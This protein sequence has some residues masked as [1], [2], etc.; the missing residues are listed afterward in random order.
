MKKILLPILVFAIVLTMSDCNSNEI[1]K[2]PEF[3]P[4]EVTNLKYEIVKGP[5]KEPVLV[6]ITWDNPSDP[7]FDHVNIGGD[8][9]TS[10]AVYYQ[11]LEMEPVAGRSIRCVNKHGKSSKGIRCTFGY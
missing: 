8:N 4:F 10:G 9:L 5:P 1:E 3:Y 6:K 11:I 2:E 7:D